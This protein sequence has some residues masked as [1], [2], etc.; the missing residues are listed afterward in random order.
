MYIYIYTYAPQIQVWDVPWCPKQ[1]PSISPRT[2]TTSRYIDIWNKTNYKHRFL[3][4]FM[5]V[6]I[7]HLSPASSCFSGTLESFG[8]F[9]TWSLTL[10]PKF[11]ANLPQIAFELWA[12]RRPNRGKFQGFIYSVMGFDGISWCFIGVKRTNMCVISYNYQEW[13]VALPYPKKIG[14]LNQS[15]QVCV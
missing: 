1:I 7:W 3:N 12:L 5:N 10:S 4:T 9:S 13:L 11:V 8:N 6:D 14:N 2:N 15:F